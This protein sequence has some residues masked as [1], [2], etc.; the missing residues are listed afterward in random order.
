MSED[1]PENPRIPQDALGHLGISQDIP[2]YPQLSRTNFP[3]V[4]ITVLAVPGLGGNI[5]I[6]IFDILLVI[7]H[8]FQS[9]LLVWGGAKI[10][11]S[12]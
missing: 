2:G 3:L 1:I 11:S 5:E 9:F 6:S 10:G 4:I 12:T 8:G 7:R